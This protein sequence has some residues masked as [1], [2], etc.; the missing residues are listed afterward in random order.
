M[1]MGI[2]YEIICWTTGLRYIG[3]TT[4]SLKSR[5]L[6]HISRIKSLDRDPSSKYVIE[7]NNYEIYKLEDCDNDILLEREDYHIKHTDC[8]NYKGAINDRKTALSNYNSSEKGKSTH[9]KYRQT[10]K[11]KN[12]IDNYKQTDTYKNYRTLKV[13]CDCGIECLKINL[14]QHIKSKKHQN[15]ILSLNK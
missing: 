8:V 11:Y 3:S 2:V 4:K 6:D 13:I 14:K 5:L 12:T 9:K 15:Y 1:K 7:H 10:E